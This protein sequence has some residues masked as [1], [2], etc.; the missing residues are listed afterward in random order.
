MKEQTRWAD[1]FV[2]ILVWI[3]FCALFYGV[4]FLMFPDA[5]T[6]D[7]AYFEGLMRNNRVFLMLTQLAMLLGTVSAIVVHSRYIVGSSFT[8]IP[9]RIRA[10]YFFAGVALGIILISIV[11]AILL[12]SKAITLYFEHVTWDLAY[13]SV[14]FLMVAYSEELLSRGYIYNILSKT[15][16][17]NI[18]LVASSLFFSFLHSLN[19]SITLIGFLNL[20]LAGLL[21]GLTY[22]AK[23][24]LSMPIGL[25][26]AWN[27]LQRPIFGFSVS[28]FTTV[29]IFQVNQLSPNLS[30]GTFGIEGSS[31]LSLTILAS[32]IVLLAIEKRSK[33]FQPHF[34]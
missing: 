33:E 2:F 29:S 24:D 16:N 17:S 21:F 11:V 28:G 9:R 12:L 6:R 3:A 26:F 18:A 27:L 20:F 32:I 10:K 1:A 13:Y 19:S 25:H 15:T 31:I 23:S 22:R 5:L 34:R 30:G 7:G 4:V 14:L 8:F